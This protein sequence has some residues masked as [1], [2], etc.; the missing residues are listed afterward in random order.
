MKILSWKIKKF[1]RAF[2]RNVKK[3][4]PYT[5]SLLK[6]NKFTYRMSKSLLSAI[7]HENVD[8]PCTVKDIVGKMCS[9]SERIRQ[10]SESFDK[11]II[12]SILVPLFNTPERYLREMIESVLYQS[13]EKWELCMADG[14][15]GQHNYVGEVCKAYAQ[16]DSRI[17]YNKL[18]QN[19]GISENTNEC[20]KMATGDYIVLFDH[21]DF[22]HPSA[23][24]K[25][26]KA[27]NE[28]GADFLY[29]DEAIFKGSDILNI[30][31]RHEKPDFAPDNLRANNYI[32]HLSVF[33][34]DLLKQVGGFRSECDGSQ[35]HDMILRLTEKAKKIY[36]IPEILYYWRSHSAS[37]AGNISSKG[38][39]VEGAKKAISDHLHRLGLDADIES[40]KI[41]P[42]FYRLRYQLKEKPKVSVVTFGNHGEKKLNKCVSSIKKKSTYN[43]YEIIATNDI[44]DGIE[45]ATGEYL[46]LFDSRNTVIT[47][48]WIEELLM[49][50]QREDVAVTGAK[51]LYPDD[52]IYHGGI[53]IEDNDK[54]T[55]AYQGKDRDE[56]GYMGRLYYSHNIPAVSGICMM[57]KTSV[58]K[59]L[60]GFDS[61]Q[62]S[63]KNAICFCLKAQE[64]GYVNVMNP[65]CQIYFYK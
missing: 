8:S 22:L 37:V 28:T 63:E 12:F 43:N 65:Y 36:H 14:S 56:T 42:T 54:F 40:T 21:D 13:Y 59:E 38:Y 47:P 41:F 50:S 7:K 60:G 58:Y 45:S 16:N 6:S 9:E 17:R 32:C 4:I 27:I 20:L 2:I 61:L 57:V 35:D 51:I 53:V 44:R 49:Y 30:V 15:D 52:S 29:S 1:I 31:T 23:L 10:Q 34:H 25:N 24:Y 62:N 55:Y 33:S 48:Q 26:A 18:A 19:K 39:A 64:Y 11:E 5:K 46:L 3:I